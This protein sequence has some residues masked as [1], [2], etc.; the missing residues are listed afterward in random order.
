M[1]NLGYTIMMIGV[2]VGL[3]LVVRAIQYLADRH[4]WAEGDA[5]SQSAHSPRPVRPP[6]MDHVR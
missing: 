1:G 4:R 6:W 3:A 2:F 5:E